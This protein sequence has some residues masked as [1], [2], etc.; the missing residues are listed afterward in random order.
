MINM[1]GVLLLPD[2]SSVTWG[3]ILAQ[4]DDQIEMVDVDGHNRSWWP[5]ILIKE[6]LSA[7]EAEKEYQNKSVYHFMTR[8]IN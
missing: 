6:Y 8:D 4:K 3:K 5:A 7:D 2:G 1:W